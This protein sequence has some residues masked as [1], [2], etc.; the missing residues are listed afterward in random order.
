[1]VFWQ[2]A[3]GM[4]FYSEDHD[5]HAQLVKFCKLNLGKSHGPVSSWWIAHVKPT[6]GYD[7]VRVVIVRDRDI[8]TMIQLMWS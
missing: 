3:L 7:K 8:S 1:M 4:A 5:Q 2:E 6:D